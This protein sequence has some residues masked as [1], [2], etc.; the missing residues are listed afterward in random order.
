MLDEIVA[1]FQTLDPAIG[2]LLRPPPTFEHELGL[3]PRA[4]PFQFRTLGEELPLEF[5][6]LTTDV[7]LDGT[8]I[9]D[10]PPVQPLVLPP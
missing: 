4:V 2:H 9:G 10:R 5:V 3:G 7:R 1:L 6:E 8:V